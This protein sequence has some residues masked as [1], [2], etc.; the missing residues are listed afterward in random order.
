MGKVK[1]Q[2]GIEPESPY[3]L[4]L[5]PNGSLTAIPKQCLPAN[6]PE[7]EKAL[8]GTKMNDHGPMEGPKT[9]AEAIYILEETNTALRSE[10][11]IVGEELHNIYRMLGLEREP[12][13]LLTM[14]MAIK[15]IALE[16]EKRITIWGTLETR[17]EK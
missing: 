13:S 10:A 7:K 12:G 6:H 2:E 11:K 15:E 14:E 3:R 1:K 9:L 16:L 17:S 8:F 4:K 5:H